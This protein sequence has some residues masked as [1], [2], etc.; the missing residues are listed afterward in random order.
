MP[1]AKETVRQEDWQYLSVG[2]WDCVNGPVI[3]TTKDGKFR[4]YYD[5]STDLFE[6]F[7]EASEWCK[8]R[9]ARFG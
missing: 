5:G 3:V 9:L 8:D 6:T 7:R 1:M 4:A 2:K